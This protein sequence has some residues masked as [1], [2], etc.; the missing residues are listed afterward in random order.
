MAEDAR[1]T[2]PLMGVVICCTSIQP[3]ARSDISSKAIAMGAF[4]R[5][6]LTSDVTHLI[7]GDLDTPKYKYVAKNRIDVKVVDGDWV[8]AMHQK[9]INGEDI[10]VSEFEEK[11]RFRTFQG[12]RI[13]VTN[14]A[15]SEER[16]AIQKLMPLHGAEY[17]PDLT[18]QVTHL[19]AA[20]P[21][22]RKYEFARQWQIKIVSPEWLYDSIQRGMAL[23]ENC[24]DPRL[25]SEKI[26]VGARPIVSVRSKS[27][28][29][30]EVDTDGGANNNKPA[31]EE[32]PQG[33]GRRIRQNVTKKIEG[34]SQSIWDDIIGQAGNSK[35]KKRDEWDESM[36]HK[37]SEETK[38]MNSRTIRAS[39]TVDDDEDEEEGDEKG[40][41]SAAKED[42]LILSAQNKHGMFGGKIFIVY[43]FDDS[44]AKVLTS[45]ITSHSGVVWS[46]SILKN[47]A[48]IPSGVQQIYI[49]VP[50]I[51][52]KSSYPKIDIFP[53]PDVVY[54]IMSYW[55]IEHCLHKKTFQQP[56]KEGDNVVDESTIFYFPFENMP[57]KG[58]NG[59]EIAVTGFTGIELLHV[60]K[61]ITLSGASYQEFLHVKRTK[62]LISAMDTIKTDKALAAIE[63]NIPV[64]TLKWLHQCILN[65]Q[66][67]DYHDYLVKG[68]RKRASSSVD[69][70]AKR[71]Q[72]PRIEKDSWSIVEM[73]DHGD[74]STS[75]I[76]GG[77]R[78]NTSTS[79]LQVIGGDRSSFVLDGCVVSISKNVKK[80]V[81]EL[82]AIASSLGATVVDNFSES[83]TELLTHLIHVEA[84][85]Q[86]T[87]KEYKVAKA[88]AGCLVVSPEWLYECKS[89]RR[90]IDEKDYPPT[91]EHI[92]ELNAALSIDP[93]VKTLQASSLTRSR[94][95]PFEVEDREQEEIDTGVSVVSAETEPLNR[96]LTT[97]LS[98]S[99]STGNENSVSAAAI[100]TVTSNTTSKPVIT[101][102]LKFGID[103]LSNV[104]DKPRKSRGKLQGRA[105]SNMSAIPDLA[106]S[107]ENS[108]ASNN[109]TRRSDTANSPQINGSSTNLGALSSASGT[110]QRRNE[111]GCALFLTQLPPQSQ[112]V[113]YADPD[114]QMERKKMIAKLNGL[115]AVESPVKQMTEPKGVVA[116]D[117]YRIR[118]S[119]RSHQD[120][121]G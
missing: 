82:K 24:Y 39:R 63:S 28:G 81:A 94:R 67:L 60:S 64:V 58:F 78:G 106:M 92:T 27:I 13:C 84:A 86:E 76:A 33:G 3:E 46:I 95:D 42:N 109:E 41:N 31:T 37:Q 108:I 104:L 12:L 53:G 5:H 119:T 70:K 59:L 52:P 14:I 113:S 55:W 25:P 91:F 18:R 45:T 120:N 117:A 69:R 118:R 107:R 15:D 100:A 103:K 57:L 101:E 50:E 105:T 74:N 99:V 85:N 10:K 17:H 49:V 79:S 1:Y 87:S 38:S 115:D 48:M 29:P 26:G 4:H 36:D 121:Q 83:N 34:H 75:T 30:G 61:T 2:H 23:D 112:A 88:M 19:I 43:G 73:P 97:L 65:G 21:E 68:I 16:L 56:K 98:D 102:F 77:L 9:W 7:V 62:V 47:R 66:W 114:A 72:L 71:P 32:L 35:A 44:K 90:K 110:S 54:T 116:Q 89:S 8:D 93:V 20:L 111:D 22:G 96:N 11:H 80:N 40:Q 6:D 51:F